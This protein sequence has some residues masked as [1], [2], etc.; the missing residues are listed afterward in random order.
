MKID[1]KSKIKTRSDKS[2]VLGANTNVCEFEIKSSLVNSAAR[3]IG[4]EGFKFKRHPKSRQD[5]FG[6]HAQ[7]AF[8]YYPL[9]PEHEDSE[10]HG[11][12]DRN[13][14]KEFNKHD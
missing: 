5:V 11:S 8:I 14:G 13:E 1:L 12:Y 7:I 4:F 2:H 3:K 6:G 10:E 9:R